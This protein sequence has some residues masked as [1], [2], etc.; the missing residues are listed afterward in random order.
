MPGK[1][2]AISEGAPQRNS[3]QAIALFSIFSPKLNDRT[4]LHCLA[5]LTSC[6]SLGKS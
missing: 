6:I 2:S 3:L 1:G 4:L 5:L